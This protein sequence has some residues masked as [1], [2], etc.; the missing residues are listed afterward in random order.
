MKNGFVGCVEADRH[1]IYISAEPNA[2]DCINSIQS[3]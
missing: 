2:S 1:K 3:D